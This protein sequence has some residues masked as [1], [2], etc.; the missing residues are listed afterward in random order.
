MAVFKY[1]ATSKYREDF[2]EV[3]TVVANSP[4]EAKRKVKALNFDKVRVARLGTLAGL[5]KKL[6]ADIK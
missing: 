4:E 2:E 5:F 6:T 3:G 1:R